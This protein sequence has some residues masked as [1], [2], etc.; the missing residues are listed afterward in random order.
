MREMYKALGEK[1][2]AAHKY[3]P[4]GADFELGLPIRGTLKEG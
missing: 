1:V 3:T 4:S 2:L